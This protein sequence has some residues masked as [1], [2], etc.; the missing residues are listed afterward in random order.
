EKDAEKKRDLADDWLIENFDR[1]K[2][3]R[4][5]IVSSIQKIKSDPKFQQNNLQQLIDESGYSQ[6]Q[7]ISLFKE[8]VGIAPKYFQRIIR[9]SEILAKIHADEKLSWT[10]IS[11]DC[12]FYDQAHFIKEFQ[13]FCGVNPKTHLENPLIDERVNFFPVD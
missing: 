6:K 12:G 10:E 4:A 9:F 3:P 8:Y 1:A 7:F 11:Y 13:H 2:I 5:A